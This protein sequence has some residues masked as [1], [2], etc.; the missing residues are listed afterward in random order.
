MFAIHQNYCHTQSNIISVIWL[1]KTPL[2]LQTYANNSKACGWFNFFFHFNDQINHSSIHFLWQIEIRVIKTISCGTKNCI[3]W[4]ENCW[5]HR[6]NFQT[7]FCEVHD[8]IQ[9]DAPEYSPYSYTLQ[10]SD[11]IENEYRNG[12]KWVF[13]SLKNT[14]FGSNE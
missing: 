9:F 4:L 1:W 5:T 6:R 7:C 13:F 3:N 8:Q 2:W 14:H 12:K 11:E 10:V